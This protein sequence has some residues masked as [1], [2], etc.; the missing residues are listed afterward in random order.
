MKG[1]RGAAARLSVALPK[2]SAGQALATA[3]LAERQGIDGLWLGA[4]SDAEPMADRY[5]LIALAAIAR[6]TGELRLG[7]VLG[8]L[9][10]DRITTAETIHLA[11]DL[12]AVDNISN[13]RLE[14]AFVPG[15]SGW[16]ERAEVFLAL[17][18]DGLELSDGRCVAV[19]PAPAQPQIP[20]LV[21]GDDADARERIN[22]GR[23]LEPGTDGGAGGSGRTVM[24]VDLPGSAS[25]WLGESPGA[26]LEALREE[27]AERRATE[28]VVVPPGG[29]S[30]EDV[31]V[32]G[33]IVGPCLR[34]APDQV[35]R[36]AVLAGTWLREGAPRSMDWT[37][38]FAVDPD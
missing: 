19:T 21:I 36:L 23:W 18:T 25:E 34:C 8:G 28:V 15:E 20:R 5:A 33:T 35:G 30:E 17:W 4:F 26:R 2:A 1:A 22:A 7:I 32:L 37:P 38:S 9:A 10:G 12:A 3:R 14:I 6:A 29:L 13:G 11:E 31:A 16:A 27:I 24:A